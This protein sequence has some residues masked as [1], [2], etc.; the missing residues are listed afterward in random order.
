MNGHPKKQ[1]FHHGDLR[2]TLIEQGIAL[3]ERDGISALTLR[4]VAAA[5][6]VSR[7]APYH[8]FRDK[9][10][11]LAAIAVVGFEKFAAALREEAAK[12]QS[13][14]DRL[15][16]LGVAYVNRARSEPQLFQLCSGT[17]I[18]DSSTYPELAQA[19][20]E[21]F[22]VLEHA[23]AHY[24]KGRSVDDITLTMASGAALAMAHG[25][26]RL[27]IEGAVRPEKEGSPSEEAFVRQSLHFLAQGVS[28]S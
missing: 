25:L 24:L 8:H 3:I 17:F 13:P 6:G 11:L 21:A 9:D 16:A 2:R 26:A 5:V 4:A 12:H 10:D 20:R 19:R 14:E 23:M 18:W 22:A 28:S 7:Q 1:S 15:I 27:L